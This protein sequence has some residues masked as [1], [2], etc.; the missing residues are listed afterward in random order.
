M[1]TP[2]SKCVEYY[3][4]YKIVATATTA[5]TGVPTIITNLYNPPVSLEVPVET[6]VRPQTIPPEVVNTIPELNIIIAEEIEKF[7]IVVD[8][9]I[10]P[11]T[12]PGDVQYNMPDPMQTEVYNSQNY[13]PRVGNRAPG[14]LPP[15]PGPGSLPATPG[16]PNE[17]HGDQGTTGIYHTVPTTTVSG[18]PVGELLKQRPGD[19]RKKNKRHRKGVGR[20]ESVSDVVDI[21]G[22]A[23]AT[24]DNQRLKYTDPNTGNLIQESRRDAFER[25][26]GL[27]TSQAPP[28]SSL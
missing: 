20:S 11:S 24:I 4:N 7:K 21:M 1:I 3:K 18:F 27:V 16:N 22:R 8:D 25:L 28:W 15:Q 13:D 2:Y 17:T 9:Y 26:L 14:I 5:G 19:T 10:D 23:L 6:H 12:S